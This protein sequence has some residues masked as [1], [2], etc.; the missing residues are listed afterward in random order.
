MTLKTKALGLIAGLI[1]VLPTAGAIALA[2]SELRLESRIRG[3]RQAAGPMTGKVTF[4]HR[5]DDV[6]RQFSV[7]IERGRPGEMFDVMISG[8]VVGTIL[9]DRTG[10]GEMDYDDSADPDDNDLPFPRNFPELDGGEVVQVGPLTGTLQ[11]K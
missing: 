11:L 5:L 4:R 2:G 10:V 8:V 7:E 9:I 6:R 3:P 1:L